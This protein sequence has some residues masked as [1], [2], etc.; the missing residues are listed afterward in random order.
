L[1]FAEPVGSPL[2]VAASLLKRVLVVHRSARPLVA[3]V[4][5][6]KSTETG[7]EGEALYWGEGESL[8]FLASVHGGEYR[9]SQAH[10][11]LWLRQFFRTDER[12]FLCYAEVNRLCAFLLPREGYRTLPWI[13]QKLP[14]NERTDQTV[15]KS[16]EE[17]YG[18]RVRRYGYQPRYCHDAGVMPE[19]FDRMYRPYITKR[20]GQ[21]AHLRSL[22]EL[23][24]IQ[25]KGF[26]LQ[27]DEQGRWVAGAVCC[28]H[29]SEVI[30]AAL[31]VAQPFEDLLHRGALSAVYYFVLRW[32][33]EHGMDFVDLLRCR[34]HITD[35]VYEHK[36]RFGAQPST[37]AWP[38]TVIGI[39]PPRSGHITSGAAGLLVCR[40]TGFET[41]AA[42]VAEDRGQPPA[43]S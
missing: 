16:V 37:D 22:D 28:V 9:L 4:G 11:W 2:L 7:H 17:V 26:L 38:H 33:R 35:G 32:A 15:S 20:F 3:W 19:F 42:C 31:A 13:R 5:P 36:R 6:L 1:W 14:L 30:V 24:R 21:A 23:T 43:E 8:S 29:G 18:R 27:I 39:Y 25:Q 12:K 10:G 40:E 34:P 41:L